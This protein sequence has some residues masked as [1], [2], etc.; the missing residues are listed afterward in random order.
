M[1]SSGNSGTHG[2]ERGTGDISDGPV[3]QEANTERMHSNV[4]D[5]DDDD[6]MRVTNSSKSHE[7]TSSVDTE[8]HDHER[9]TGHISDGSVDQEDSSERMHSNVHDEEDDDRMRVTN[10]SKSHELTSSVDTE[11]HDHERGTGHISDGSV[12]QED[13]SERTSED[14][15]IEDIDVPESLEEYSD[16]EYE[17]LEY[18]SV[19][20]S[21]E[22]LSSV[23][24]GVEDAAKRFYRKHHKVMKKLLPS[25]LPGR[26]KSFQGFLQETF[27]NSNTARS[28]PIE[29]AG[30]NAS[31]SVSRLRAFLA[32]AFPPVVVESLAAEHVQS[33]NKGKHFP[34]FSH[35]SGSTIKCEICIPQQKWAMENHQKYHKLKTKQVSTQSNLDGTAVLTFS[36]VVQV[37]EHSRSK[38]HQDAL[39][40]FTEEKPAMKSKTPSRE[41]TT[42]R[43]P[44]DIMAYFKAPLN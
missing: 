33:A 18:D 16:M 21:E 23:V 41:K 3:D 22:V 19:G 14:E 20:E 28:G 5:E 35:S 42:K 4:H 9:G 17:E 11:I 36:G 2:H 13:S 30:K 40:F 8:I 10:S 39:R 26:H 15:T 29:A 32:V 25:Q 7:L 37:E 38:C 12:D 44:K 31:L 1:S 43:A 27:P 6:G 34:Q 24:E